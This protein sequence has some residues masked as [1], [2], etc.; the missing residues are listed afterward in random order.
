MRLVSDP[1]GR[2][3]ETIGLARDAIPVFEAI[4]DDRALGRAWRFL[5]H[6]RGAMQCHYA[7]AVDAVER[8]LA[9][10]ERCGWPTWGCAGDLA[11]FVYYGPTHVE[12][13]AARC[14]RLLA[15]TSRA[16]EATVLTFLGGLEG[17]RG[18]FDEARRLVSKARRLYDEL[19]QP[20]GGEVNYGTVAA[21]IELLAG[22]YAA[23]EQILR[24]SCA[25]LERMG[26][27]AFL[28][29]RATQ[30]AEVLWI[31]GCDAEAEVWVSRAAE[32]GASDD[33]PT[34]LYWRCVQG[35]V[36]AR[37]GEGAE[38]ER[39]VRE[40]IRLSEPTDALNHQ[41]RA[42]LALAQVLGLAGR[43]PDAAAEANA[44]V[45]LFERKG[46]AVSVEDARA[47]LAEF[48]VA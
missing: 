38:A 3:A 20:S 48:A 21:R 16:G 45:V 15:E 6:V 29:T 10:Y 14:R 28:S 5:G 9:C 2:A 26:N 1:E 46:N 33:I 13:A 30:L 37:R 34:Q 44:A 24:A 42:H 19:G 8:A 4:E 32:L 41:A 35:K 17:M 22:E 12:E 23:A 43:M 18:D 40:A 47:L 27:R 36:L 7:V 31:R 39:L 11:S 25:A